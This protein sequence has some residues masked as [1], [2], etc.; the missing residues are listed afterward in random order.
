MY[1]EQL[2]IVHV[3][4][5]LLLLL[6]LRRSPEMGRLVA[7]PYTTNKNLTN[8]AL[9]NNLDVF[10][11]LPSTY[12]GCA[13]VE[14]DR[15]K[16]GRWKDK[17]LGV[18]GPKKAPSHGRVRDAPA[19]LRQLRCISPATN[20]ARAD[21]VDRCRL[22]AQART[23]PRTHR[24]TPLAHLSCADSQRRRRHRCETGGPRG[25]HL[26]LPLRQGVQAHV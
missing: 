24:R 10:H 3:G 15:V 4:G 17:Q 5:V 18:E 14:Q 22:Q 20:R 13:Y 26:R 23:H 9:E 25:R 16:P 21:E 2:P 1:V 8:T 7:G 19:A 12:N 6:L 11:Y